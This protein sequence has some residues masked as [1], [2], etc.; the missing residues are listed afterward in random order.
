[1]IIRSKEINSIDR[2]GYIIKRLFTKVFKDAPRD[3]GFYETT[4]PKGGICKEQWHKKSYEVVYF[5]S[6]ANAKI[7]GNEYYLGKGD[8]VILDPGEKH[9][10]RAI[11][12]DV[13]VFAMRFPHLLDD[14]YTAE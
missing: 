1:M 4:I 8:L 14:K 11:D 3:A 5:L 13:T 6:P 9:E 7:E 12:R 2:G 10:W